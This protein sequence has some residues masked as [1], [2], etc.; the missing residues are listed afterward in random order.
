MKNVNQILRNEAFFKEYITLYHSPIVRAIRNINRLNKVNL[1]EGY[2]LVKKKI[3]AKIGDIK[4]KRNVKSI[5]SYSSYYNVG[6][7]VDNLKIAVYGC[8]TNNYDTIKE[9][10]YVGGDTT[11]YVFTDKLSEVNG[12]WHEK[13]LDCGMY[14]NEANRYYKFHPFDLFSDYDFAIYIDGNVRILSDVSTIC[15]IAAKAKT[16]IAMH[17]HHERECAYQEALACKYYKRGNYK[18]I[19]EQISRFRDDGFPEDFGLCEA[20]IIVYDLKNP[21][22][23]VIT[24]QWWKEYLQSCT[25]RDQ[26]SFPYVLW[27][28]GFG[29]NDVGDL[30]NNLMENP[31]FLI[32]GH[33]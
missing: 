19:L 2:R 13:L 16:G 14:A 9:P 20:T 8:I 3:L 30:G 11:Y 15:S 29:I 26:I 33:S 21:T 6:E 27:Q 10:L 12:V 28:N 5:R 7:P 25:K 24:E 1:H 18:R 22:A 31:K 23:K 4:I 32:T 17:R